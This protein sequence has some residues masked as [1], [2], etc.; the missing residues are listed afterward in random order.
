MYSPCQ[1]LGD[2]NAQ[3]FETTHTLHCSLIDVE[4]GVGLLL[5]V[6][7]VNYQLLGFADIQ[8]VCL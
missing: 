6:A 3:I 8:L 1:I 2:V 5:S 4:G 7:E